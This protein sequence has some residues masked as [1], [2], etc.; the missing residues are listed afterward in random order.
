MKSFW[1]VLLFVVLVACSPSS[2]VITPSS[3]ANIVSTNTAVASLD[4]PTSV[5]PS[6]S[7]PPTDTISIPTSITPEVKA[8]VPDMREVELSDLGLSHTTRLILYYQPS[9]S[10]R[11]MSVQ[12]SQPQKIPNIASDAW[13]FIGIDISPDH[14][15]FIY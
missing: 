14:K 6:E 2:V 12:D 10:L 13:L 5:V 4:S 15:W 7:V 11:I 3:T 9:E 1:G 8:I